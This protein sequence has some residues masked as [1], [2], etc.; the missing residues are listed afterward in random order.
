MVLG[1][2]GNYIDRVYLSSVSRICN[3]EDPSLLWTPVSVK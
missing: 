2:L 1:V 3:R